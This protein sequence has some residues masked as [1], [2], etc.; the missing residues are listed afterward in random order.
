MEKIYI[1]PAPASVDDRINVLA[2][3]SIIP[4]TSSSML[5]SFKYFVLSKAFE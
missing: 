1:S 3:L 5:N 4:L 2:E